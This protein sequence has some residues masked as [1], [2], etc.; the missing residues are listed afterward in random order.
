MLTPVNAASPG[1]RLNFEEGARLIINCAANATSKWQAFW[2]PPPR[3]ERQASPGN[4][5][6]IGTCDPRGRCQPGHLSDKRLRYVSERSSEIVTLSASRNSSAGTYKC[7]A[8]SPQHPGEMHSAMCVTD[9]IVRVDPA[10]TDCHVSI[11]ATHWV[12]YGT[13]LITRVYSALKNYTCQ[14]YTD[15]YFQNRRI[16]MSVGNNHLH[17]MFDKIP[18]EMTTLRLRPFHDARTGREFMRGW[19][20]FRQVVPISPSRYR[21]TLE[22]FAVFS[23][24]IRSRSALLVTDPPTKPKVDCPETPLSPGKEISCSC[25]AD[26]IGTPHGWLVWRS[27]EGEMARG[28]PGQ[29]SLR[30]T[31]VPRPGV[32]TFTCQLVW[33]EQM[34]TSVTLETKAE[35]VIQSIT[36]NGKSGMLRVSENS[37]VTLT[38]RAIGD[39]IPQMQLF[40]AGNVTT[41]VTVHDTTAKVATIHRVL[42]LARC[43]RAIFACTAQNRLGEGHNATSVL[44]VTCAPRLVKTED[45]GMPTLVYANEHDVSQARLLFAAYP[46]VLQP[47]VTFHAAR[48]GQI[49]TEKGRELCCDKMSVVCEELPVYPVRVRCVITARNLTSR[50]MGMYVLRLTNTEGSTRVHFVVEARQPGFRARRGPR[51]EQEV[52]WTARHDPFAWLL[53]FVLLCVLILSVAALFR[54][55]QSL[56]LSDNENND[57]E[58]SG[59]NNYN[60]NR[61]ISDMVVKQTKTGED[62][63]RETTSLEE[64]HIPPKKCKES[65][66]PVNSCANDKLCTTEHTGEYVSLSGGRAGETVAGTKHAECKLSEQMLPSKSRPEPDDTFVVVDLSSP[67]KKDCERYVPFSTY[68][69]KQFPKKLEPRSWLRSLRLSMT[70]KQNVGEQADLTPTETVQVYDFTPYDLFRRRLSEPSS[71]VS[72]LCDIW[73]QEKSRTIPLTSHSPSTRYANLPPKGMDLKS[74]NPLSMDGVKHSLH[75]DPEDVHRESGVDVDQKTPITSQTSPRPKSKVENAQVS[76][77][78]LSVGSPSP[79]PSRFNPFLVSDYAK[80]EQGGVSAYDRVGTNSKLSSPSVRKTCTT[81]YHGRNITCA[82]CTSPQYRDIFSQHTETADLP[83]TGTDVSYIKD[84][85]TAD[86]KGI[87][88]TDQQ[89][90]LIS[91]KNQDSGRQRSSRFTLS[92]RTSHQ[93]TNQIVGSQTLQS[94]DSKSDPDN[95][96][97]RSRLPSTKGTDAD[98]RKDAGPINQARDLH[99][100]KSEVP[101]QE[102]GISQHKKRRA[103]SPPKSD[104]PNTKAAASNARNYRSTKSRNSSPE[105]FHSGSTRRQHEYSEITGCVTQD[106]QTKI[107]SRNHQ[108]SEPKYERIH[109]SENGTSS[110]GAASSTEKHRS[111]PAPAHA[112]YDALA[113]SAQGKHSKSNAQLQEQPSLSCPK[114]GAP[115]PKPS[116]TRSEERSPVYESISPWTEEGED[117]ASPHDATL[118]L[119]THTSGETQVVENTEARSSKPSLGESASKKT[120]S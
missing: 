83:S 41:G 98:D 18:Q 88:E 27:E 19:C 106:T 95:G 113:D 99:V 54:R 87:A 3:A 24:D 28:L 30:L 5:S 49:H 102:T 81:H 51:E 64:N 77:S 7:E 117:L 44:E 33:I 78:P 45:T 79:S 86:G 63:K 29:A 93:Y 116:S 69:R 14:W 9:V 43:G 67:E 103:P 22:Y 10:V 32:Q 91:A 114:R 68:E 115:T 62:L 70:N 50:E 72:T 58:D 92:E 6:L 82:L 108:A 85:P 17:K 74:E 25:S 13:C 37:S 90:E 2:A 75:H 105:V 8:I 71:R 89:E 57:R 96:N 23:P 110:C 120:S 36:L 61:K 66:E 48:T 39:P 16:Q 21:R 26:S 94:N 107:S 119:S 40:V 65:T 12:V 100:D 104:I 118:K 55:R 101:E 34:T 47:V 1:C 112:K 20:N 109:D 60:F 80:A 84:Q 42:S 15:E 35:A 111:S 97:S 73:G 59:K 31:F 76:S 46:A 4:F 52:G 11:D 53:V 38:C 56:I